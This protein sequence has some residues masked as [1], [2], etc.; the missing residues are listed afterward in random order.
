VV[1]APGLRPTPDR[2][3]ET[4]FNWI[5]QWIRDWAST[6]VLDLFAGSGAL[7]FECASRGA[8]QVTLVERHAGALAALRAL[9]QRLGCA[10]VHIIA[11][12]WAEAIGRMAD[13]SRQLVFLDPP[14]AEGLLPQALAASARV[15]AGGG[16]LYVES[17]GALE[18]SAWEQGPF[19]LL[20]KSQAGAVH[21]HLLR[22]RSC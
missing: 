14:F 16:L 5:E 1:T 6:S 17:G 7:G 2:V 21:F 12:D 20:R 19:E 11:A 15:L 18:D 9:Q 3:R 22:R 10:Q 13:G 4:A 8:A